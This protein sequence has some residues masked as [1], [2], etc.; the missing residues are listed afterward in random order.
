MSSVIFWL[1]QN[2][3]TILMAGTMRIPE[4]FLLSLVYRLI[5]GE[6]ETYVSIIWTAFFGGLLWDL[7]WV[8]VPFF[9]LCYV[10]VIMIVIWTWSTLP[11]PGRTPYVVFFIFWAA[12]LL[13]S[14]LFALILERKTGNLSWALLV[15]QQLAAMPVSLLGT[16]FYFQQ[17]KNRNA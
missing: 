10:V 5:T 3:L 12:Q 15:V 13:P 8:G 16:F 4:I 7:R 9:T 17:E 6:R 14:V 2:L 1:T 11:L